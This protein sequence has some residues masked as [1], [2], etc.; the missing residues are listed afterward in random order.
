MAVS[1]RPRVPPTVDLSAGGLRVVV[2]ASRWNGA[3]VERLLVG[4][5]KALL[6]L[7]AGEDDIEVHFVPGAFELPAAAAAAAARADVDAI[8]VLGCI[9]RGETVHF[10]LIAH[11]ATAGIEAVARTS[12][13]AIGFGVLAV[14]DEA[15]AIA[16]TEPGPAHAGGN[17]ARAAIEMHHVL[18]ALRSGEGTR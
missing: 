12:G 4:A 18:A 5:R 17:A 13:K 8:V 11:A 9:V 10:D 3:V 16:R 6:E 7:G 2:L 1:E 15:Q 14:D